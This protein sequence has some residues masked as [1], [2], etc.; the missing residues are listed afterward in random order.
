MS[1]EPHDNDFG[2]LH[3]RMEKLE[4]AARQIGLYLEQG[5]VAVGEDGQQAIIASFSI[6]KVAFSERVQNPE[7]HSI[8][9]EFKNIA[10]SAAKDDF[11]DA[12]QKIAEALERGEDPFLEDE[13]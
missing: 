5:G 13:E 12:R 7:K 10:T 4:D 1:L 8:D 9:S 6:N 11:L 3:Q 2:D